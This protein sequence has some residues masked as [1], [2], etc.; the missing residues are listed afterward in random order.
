MVFADGVAL[1][2]LTVCVAMFLW[3]AFRT[4]PEH[5]TIEGHLLASRGIDSTSFG[6]TLVAASTSL[7][8]VILFFVGNAEKFGLT[9]VFCGVTYLLGQ[10]VFIST[11]GKVGL[12]TEDMT[13]NADFWRLWTTCPSVSRV[14]SILTAVSFL[15]ILFVE[16]SVGSVIL[17]YYLKSFT[18][19]GVASP[20]AR[21]LAF[22]ALGLLVVGYVRTGGLSIVVRTD[23]WQL[24][25]MLIAVGALLLFGILGSQQVVSNSV[26]WENFWSF[27]AS[28]AHVFVFWAWIA[29]LNFTLPF[30]QLSSWQRLAG[31]ESIGK[32]W[33][34]LLFSIPTFLM[35]WIGP[36]IALVLLKA[37]GYSF[38][39]VGPL[40]DAMKGAGGIVAVFL[41]PCVFVGF[42]CALFSSADSALIALQLSLADRSTFVDKLTSLPE[43]SLRRILLG[44]SIVVIL[45]LSSIFVT[46]E[47]NIGSWFIPIIYVIF[48]QLTIIGPQLAYALWRAK[49]HSPVNLST[50][51]AIAVV[52]AIFAGWT[53]LVVGALAAMSESYK[54]SPVQEIATF[55]AVAISSLGM[56]VGHCLRHDVDKDGPSES[57]VPDE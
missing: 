50:S 49:K 24:R 32:A 44:A 3:L 27:S 53:I 23:A 19:A 47:A 15:I 55:I 38:T 36:V 6:S 41:F 11:V 10:I 21:G 12:E 30:T 14:I 46:Q 51:G 42:A 48:S 28:W 5:L 7:A 40:F 37:R 34:G 45:L 13:T 18:I 35:M 29:M 1:L 22:L 43:V 33:L 39:E 25:L 17:T 20:F 16:L 9:L 26:D 52:L 8:T 56:I 57:G 4:R 54:D 2:G 31:A